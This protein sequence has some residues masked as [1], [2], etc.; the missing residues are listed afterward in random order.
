MYSSGSNQKEQLK[1]K[2][3]VWMQTSAVGTKANM[4]YWIIRQFDIH[5][6]I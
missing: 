3:Q 6:N 1:Y 2:S 5:V 4:E